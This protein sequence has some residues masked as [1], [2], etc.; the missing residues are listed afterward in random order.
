MLGRKAQALVPTKLG[1]VLGL[2]R[3]SVAKQQQLP[4]QILKHESSQ[5]TA[6]LQLKGEFFLEGRSERHTSMA[7]I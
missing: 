6:G 1:H 5:L 3:K 2:F 7:V 4:Q